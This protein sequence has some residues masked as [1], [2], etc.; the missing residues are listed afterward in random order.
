MKMREES[1]TKLVR[2]LFLEH[3]LIVHSFFMLNFLKNWELY[4]EL[5][6]GLSNNQGAWWPHAYGYC[7]S[8]W[9]ERC[10]SPCHGHFSVF[11][12]NILSQCF[13]PSRCINGYWVI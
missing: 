5:S 8:L 7:A 10:L 3:M 4:I 2:D 13:A 9:I 6:S 11:L 12:S 1:L